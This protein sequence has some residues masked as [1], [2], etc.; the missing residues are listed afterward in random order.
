[1]ANITER[2][3]IE[4]TVELTNEERDAFKTVIN[5]LVDMGHNDVEVKGWGDDGDFH[6]NETD[7]IDLS[8]QLSEILIGSDTIT[9]E[10]KY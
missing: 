3:V 7:L 6:Y 5:L 9:Y 10:D 2:K 8:N 1:M 4:Y